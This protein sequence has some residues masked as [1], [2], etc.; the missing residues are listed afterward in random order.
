VP[1]YDHPEPAKSLL[2]T[3]AGPNVGVKRVIK[4]AK[5]EAPF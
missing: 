2:T 5:D 3:N 1:L 4:K